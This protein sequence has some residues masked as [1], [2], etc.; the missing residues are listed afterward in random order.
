MTPRLRHKITGL[1]LLAALL[2][3]LAISALLIYVK[4]EAERMVEK[5][6]K[7][8]SRE[9]TRQAA[10]SVNSLCSTIHDLTQQQV[11][12][13]LGLAQNLLA[14]RGT[15]RLSDKQRVLWRA[16]NQWT[17]KIREVT[18]PQILFGE[19]I[20]TE[21]KGS[22]EASSLVDEVKRLSGATCTLFQQLTDGSMLRIATTVE[23]ADGSRAI[24]SFLP[25]QDPNGETN[26]IIA[27]VK[28]GETYRGY[29][30]VG[31]SSFI[32]SYTGLKDS[33]GEV[34]GMI[35]VGANL[36]HMKGLRETILQTRMGQDGYVYVLQ[37]SGP[38]RGSYIISKDGRRDGENL[39]RA[40]DGSGRFFIQEI[41]KKALP[42]Q[43][44]E[45]EYDT[46]PWRNRGERQGRLKT[47]AFTYF[48]PWDWII[49]AGL[50]HDDYATPAQRI[51][52]PLSS[53]WLGSFWLGLISLLVVIVL[54]IVLGQRIAA[55]IA[56]ITIVARV[57]AE[58]NLKKA[59]AIMKAEYHQLTR[60]GEEGTPSTRQGLDET[61]QLVY[62]IAAMTKNLNSLVG[63]AK[64]STVLLVSSA[65][66]IAASSKQQEATFNDLGTSANE[67]AASVRQIS[68]TSQDLVRT[69]VQVTEQTEETAELANAGRNGLDTMEK[70]MRGLTGATQSISDK[71]AVIS[72]KASNIT[73]I[74]TTI[75]KVADQTNLLSLNAAIEAEK[76]GEQGLGFGVVAREIRRLADQTAVATLDIEQMIREMQSAVSA[77]VMEMDRFN[78]IMR[79]GVEEMEQIGR[80]LA[81]IITQ[82]AQMLP[83]FQLVQE[84]MMSQSQGAQQINE[85]MIQLTGGTH[86]A[87]ESL[88][89]FNLATDSMHNA[90][91][92]L[93][94]E[95]SHFKVE[96]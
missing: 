13:N 94:E 22:D 42:L 59:E 8:I 78:E 23:N 38:D 84:G 67:I 40:T 79:R 48:Q 76:A 57:V 86:H 17:G 43:P 51:I 5:N 26:S 75:T 10:L 60:Q 9:Q 82:V 25:S 33:R 83:Q 64:R 72:N 53:L 46:Y 69:I 39:W 70:Q 6:T 88:H 15:L 90:M 56:K 63:Q 7:E 61:A 65:T 20:G 45:V 28:K 1:A 55:P 74:M 80:Q 3:L 68:A 11:N 81:Q 30:R 52:Q 24:G 41:I 47:A 4:G 21:K 12:L 14:R 96:D 93:R 89:E 62:A 50:Y 95:I 2:P 54:S 77:G 44:G 37:G 71:L 49:A 31:P 29:S 19:N 32:T 87:L 92:N 36:R 91:R 18:L 58:G 66:E 35:A 34:I 27:T 73:L 16:K 85:A